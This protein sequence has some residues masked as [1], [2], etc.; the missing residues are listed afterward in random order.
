MDELVDMMATEPA[1]AAAATAARERGEYD[2][3]IQHRLF[4]QIV[5]AAN[6]YSNLQRD[7]WLDLGDLALGEQAMDSWGVL[8]TTVME[9]LREAV[10]FIPEGSERKAS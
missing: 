10:A 4:E 6:R 9:C 1:R 8:C 7:H 5:D 2:W 3:E